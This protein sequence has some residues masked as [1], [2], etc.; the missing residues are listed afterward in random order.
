M[1]LALPLNLRSAVDVASWMSIPESRLASSALNP[2]MSSS[3]VCEI[4]VRLISELALSFIFSEPEP[5][6]TNMTSEALTVWLLPQSSVP[7]IVYTPGR[8]L[9]S[10]AIVMLE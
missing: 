4:P 8:K 10:Q 6:R 9:V 3:V 5:V 2:Y 1:A 7:L